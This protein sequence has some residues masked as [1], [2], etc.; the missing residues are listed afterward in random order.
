MYREMNMSYA[1][2]K[3]VRSTLAGTT[4]Y[5]QRDLHYSPF[6]VDFPRQNVYRT[7]IPRGALAV[8]A[9]LS[10]FE[11]NIKPTAIQKDSIADGVGD[12]IVP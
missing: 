8:T 11:M 4:Y 5:I 12:E 9:D 2:W 6:L 1:Q 7:E 10:D 3:A